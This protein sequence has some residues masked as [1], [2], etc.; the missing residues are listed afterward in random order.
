MP[1]YKENLK[2]TV[3]YK[4]YTKGSFDKCTHYM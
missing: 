1:D 4:K 3:Q 2:L